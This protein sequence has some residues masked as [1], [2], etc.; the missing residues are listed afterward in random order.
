MIGF[1]AR[2]DE[3]RSLGYSDEFMRMWQFYL[4]YCESEFIERVIG[5][6]QMLIMRPGARCDRIRY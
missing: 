4:G 1:F 3:V 5:N 2:I 6:V